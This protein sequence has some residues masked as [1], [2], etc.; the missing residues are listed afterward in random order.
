MSGDKKRR[1]RGELRARHIRFV[2]PRWLKCAD[3]DKISKLYARAKQ[4]REAGHD[5]QIDHIVPLFSDY[6]CR[7]HV[8]WNL[9]IY[10]TG[11]N[12]YRSNNYWPGCPWENHTWL[13]YEFPE[14][15]Q[16]KLF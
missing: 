5:V 3:R 8:P 16:L 7:L 14:P 4:M 2:T 12:R 1:S 6:V 9:R 10:P 13:D 11:P 15:H